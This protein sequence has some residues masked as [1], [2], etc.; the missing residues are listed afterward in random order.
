V[1][2]DESTFHAN[3]DQSFHWSDGSNQALK[4]KSLG[5]AVMISEIIDEVDG[6]LKFGEEEARLT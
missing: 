4:Q 2:H 5:Q 1:F 3:A 6:Y